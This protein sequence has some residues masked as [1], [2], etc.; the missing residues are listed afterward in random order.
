MLSALK[1]LRCISGA[2]LFS[3]LFGQALAAESEGI[4]SAAASVTTEVSAALST[5]ASAPAV[6]VS[7]SAANVP[8]PPALPPITPINVVTPPPTSADLA[9]LRRGAQTFA[10]Y[11]MA[12]HSASLVQYGQLKALGFSTSQINSDID[13]S[14]AKL[15][16]PMAAMM[17]ADDAQKA[18]GSAPPDLSLA[19]RTHGAAWLYTYL[20]SFYIDPDR[21]QGANNLLVPGVGM[22]D[23]L[24]G[25]H[26][27]R[28]AVF[29]TKGTYAG[30]PAQKTRVFVKFEQMAPGSLSSEAYDSTLADLV[31]YMG[32]M[33][34]PAQLPR[35]RLG[36]WVLG[37]LLL[38]SFTAWRLVRSYWRSHA[39]KA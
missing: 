29:A 15:D 18:F 6:A 27:P 33:A 12:C 1:L 16:A 39:S 8:L 20:R 5:P 10:T 32:W 25:L 14:G 22:P 2:M 19:A 35:H 3:A 11:C 7:A 13:A 37:F 9:S 34:E 30:L 21:P 4:R 31:A 23:I 36:P 24:A 17:S 28:T 38:F 26:G